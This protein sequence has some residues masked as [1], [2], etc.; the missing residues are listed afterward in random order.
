M[1]MIIEADY[2]G[3]SVKAAGFVRELVRKKPNCVLGLAT[4]STPIGLYKELIR[5]S[6]ED[7]LDFSQVTTFN[8]DEYLGLGPTHDQSYRYFMEQNLFDKLKTRPKLTH[9]PAGL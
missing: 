2:Q 8:L 6:H 4:G 7:G 3:M 9:V 1:R 5:L